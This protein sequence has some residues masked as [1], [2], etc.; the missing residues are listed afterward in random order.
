MARCFRTIKVSTTTASIPFNSTSTDLESHLEQQNKVSTYLHLPLHLY[1]LSRTPI[2]SLLTAKV[3]LWRPKAEAGALE[4]LGL[5]VVL[6]VLVVTSA[7]ALGGSPDL[8]K[9]LN[10]AIYPKSYLETLYVLDCIP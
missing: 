9:V 7:L 8:P 3:A 1:T 10:E 2:R 4:R 5:H 6:L